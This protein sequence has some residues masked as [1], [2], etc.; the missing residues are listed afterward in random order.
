MSKKKRIALVA[1]ICTIIVVVIIVIIYRN[2]QVENIIY[3]ENNNQIAEN[4]N[5][6]NET[7]EQDITE[8]QINSI[9]NIKENEIVE[10]SLMENNET[11]EQTQTTTKKENNESEKQ[12]QSQSNKQTETTKQEQPKT[13][14]PTSQI[15]IQELPKQEPQEEQIIKPVVEKCTNNNNHS[16]GVGNS[17]K[18]FNTKAEAVAVFE[19][20]KSKWENKWT[21]FEIDD[22]TYYKN[23]PDSYEV[24]S[25]SQCGKWTISIFYD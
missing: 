7:I 20:E 4:F 17:G 2:K 5:S 23:C 19:N 14:E 10:Q 11:K 16:I 12:T 6:Q 3:G 1:I 8:N 21:N 13:E 9:D 24:Y 15:P 18:W 25:C 22:E